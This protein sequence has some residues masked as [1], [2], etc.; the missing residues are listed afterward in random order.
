VNQS[1]KKVELEFLSIDVSQINQVDLK[2]L[3]PL[4]VQIAS[5]STMVES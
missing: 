2:K 4:V 3:C 5:V 1:L